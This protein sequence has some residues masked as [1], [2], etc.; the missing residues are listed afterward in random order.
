MLKVHE[1]TRADGSLAPVFLALD[2]G[3]LVLTSDQGAMDLPDGS[4]EAV[5]ARFGKP[6]EPKEPLM[7]IA[8]MDLGRGRTLRHVRHLATFDVIARDWLV[9]AVPSEAT[10]SEPLGALAATV[11]GALLHLARAANAR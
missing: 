7:E 6:I 8:A 11:A 9:Y 4:L 2:R 3:V 5:M 10:P 1:T